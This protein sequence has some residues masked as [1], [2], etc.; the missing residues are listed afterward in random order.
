[1]GGCAAVIFFRWLAW[2]W[3]YRDR[4]A[5]A[6]EPRCGGCGYIIARG[7][8]VVCSECGG[9]VREVGIVTPAT[10]F[11]RSSRAWYVLVALLAAPVG[12]AVARVVEERQPFG[13]EF[14]L[15]RWVYIDETPMGLHRFVVQASGTGRYFERR[16]EHI[17]VYEQPRSTAHP[18]L[19]LVIAVPGMTY[20]PFVGAGDTVRPGVPFTRGA[21]EE[22]IQAA[23]PDQPASTR[24]RVVSELEDHVWAV[25]RGDFSVSERTLSVADALPREALGYRLSNMS[26]FLVH[27][28]CVAAVPP[29]PLWFMRRALRQ[30][31]DSMRRKWRRAAG[32]MRLVEQADVGRDGVVAQGAQR[33]TP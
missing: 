11:G 20:R 31:H 9:D 29:V 17:M 7:G 28:L 5:L 13:W 14:S 2:R 16:P 30:R 33:P 19:G 27:L 15:S 4:R 32:E 1:M 10:R 6:A 3:K 18:G 22:M 26:R 21:L 8:S 24:Q 12:V 25:A 23:A